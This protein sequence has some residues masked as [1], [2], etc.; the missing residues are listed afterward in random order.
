MLQRPLEL[1][2]QRGLTKSSSTSGPT[3]E[4]W[5]VSGGGENGATCHNSLVGPAGL[6]SPTEPPAHCAVARMS[7]IR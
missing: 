7:Y 6:D 3:G 5:R 4:L 2:A 1:K